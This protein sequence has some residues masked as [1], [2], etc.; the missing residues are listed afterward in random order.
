MKEIF[1]NKIK[2][3][4]KQLKTV[5]NKNKTRENIYEAKY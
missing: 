3:E 2:H 5:E 1:E 4:G